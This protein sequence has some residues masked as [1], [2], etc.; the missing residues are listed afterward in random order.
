M[1]ISINKISSLTE[2]ML[3]GNTLSDKR[4]KKLVENE[5]T[6][7]RQVLDYIR[8]HCSKQSGAT[9]KGKKG[10]KGKNSK[11]N[12]DEVCCRNSKVYKTEF[13]NLECQK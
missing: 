12:K 7:S 3:K 1:F 11:E 9:G 8:Q 10:K 13:I 4:L 6:L 5:R 2:I